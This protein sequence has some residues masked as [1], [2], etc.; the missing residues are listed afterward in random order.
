MLNRVFVT[1]PSGDQI[2]TILSTEP[3]SRMVPKTNGDPGFWKNDYAD[4]VQLAPDGATVY[5]QSDINLAFV[6]PREEI[7]EALDVNP[8]TGECVSTTVEIPGALA[9]LFNRHQDT[10]ASR[11]ANGGGTEAEH[12]ANAAAE[13]SE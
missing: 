12:V 8:E 1:L 9:F 6:K 11:N 5:P 4:G 13:A 7:I 2:P 10:L 3:E